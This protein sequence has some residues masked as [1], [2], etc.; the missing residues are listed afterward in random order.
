MSGGRGEGAYR[1]SGLP[2]PRFG[3]SLN[4]NYHFHAYVLEGLYEAEAE[5]VRFHEVA[6]LG[7]A[8]ILQVQ[9]RARRRVLEAFV[10]WGAN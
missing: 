6:E 1:C 5:G 10:R 4:A 9:E 2:L 3:S 8:A 7:E